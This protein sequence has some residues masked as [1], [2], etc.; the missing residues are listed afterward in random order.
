MISRGDKAVKPAAI[1]NCAP[2]GISPCTKHEKVS[3]ILALLRGSTP[4]RSAIRFAIGPTVIIAIVLL[5]VQQVSDTYQRSYT[6]FGSPFI[7]DTAGQPV[8][9]V[10]NTSTH[11]DQL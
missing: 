8:N 9:H 2:Y 6:Q 3:R 7:A 4:N 11:P 5:A 10:I 1:N